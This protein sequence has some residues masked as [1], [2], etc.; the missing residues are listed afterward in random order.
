MDRY[1]LPVDQQ[2]GQYQQKVR[3]PGAGAAKHPVR[4]WR[5]V[6]E[7]FT[8]LLKSYQEGMRMATT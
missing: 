5:I 3:I 2:E 6:A 4:V 7:R 8:V 1:L